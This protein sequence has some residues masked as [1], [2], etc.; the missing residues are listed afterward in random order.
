MNFPKT[1]DTQQLKV[2]TILT[3]KEVTRMNAR[4]KRFA[5]YGYNPIH[6]FGDFWLVRNRSRNFCKISWYRIC[7]LPDVD[8]ME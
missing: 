6:L 4:V 3:E 1:L 7:Y 5:D 8:I 2:Y